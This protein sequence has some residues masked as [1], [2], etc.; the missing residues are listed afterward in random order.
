MQHTFSISLF[1]ETVAEVSKELEAKDDS[2]VAKRLTG[3]ANK[4]SVGDSNKGDNGKSDGE[5][6]ESL[7]RISDDRKSSS[8]VYAVFLL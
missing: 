2:E 8:G 7:V 6:P 4:H 3:A 1:Q 5:F